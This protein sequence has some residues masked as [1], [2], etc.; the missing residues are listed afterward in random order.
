MMCPY[1]I[2]RNHVVSNLLF[3]AVEHLRRW[4]SGVI[5]TSVVAVL[6][7]HFAVIFDVHLTVFSAYCLVK[8]RT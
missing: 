1:T 2:T 8:E 3:V 5:M 6:R 7:V 4:S